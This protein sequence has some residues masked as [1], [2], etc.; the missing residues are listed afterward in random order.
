MNHLPG[1]IAQSR[2]LEMQ[3]GRREACAQGRYTPEGGSERRGNYDAS[4]EFGKLQ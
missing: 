3:N 4:A 1:C 2:K